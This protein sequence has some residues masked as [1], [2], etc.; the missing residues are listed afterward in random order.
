[1]L[2]D[3]PFRVG[4]VIQVPNVTGRAVVTAI[5]LRLTELKCVRN[6]T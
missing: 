1:L 6:V 4:D 3:A 5:R 2:S